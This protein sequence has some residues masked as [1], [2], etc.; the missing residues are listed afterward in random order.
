M[1]AVLEAEVSCA[2]QIVA[3]ALKELQAF[4]VYYQ[5]QIA[6]AIGQQLSN[7]PNVP[8]RH[9]KPLTITE[10]S[11]AFDPPSW[12]L[13]FGDIR[14]F[15]DLDDTQQIVFIRAV[16]AKPPHAKTEDVL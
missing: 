15:Y 9:R 7:Q 4:K 14:V 16:R 10:A 8:T 13:R 12:E 3:S 5:R 1:S 2:I 11:F 6:D